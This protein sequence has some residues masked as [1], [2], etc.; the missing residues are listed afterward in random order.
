MTDNEKKKGWLTIIDADGN[1]LS[2]MCVND[3]SINF[4][5]QTDGHRVRYDLRARMR[6]AAWHMKSIRDSLRNI[7]RRLDDI[8]RCCAR[9]RNV[10][11]W[12]AT[13]V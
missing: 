3:W 12:T 11:T 9:N 10:R 1:P 6:S 13:G 5:G 7:S 8:V 2:V 4:D